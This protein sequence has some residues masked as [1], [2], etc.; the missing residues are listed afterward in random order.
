MA[1][2]GRRLVSGRDFAENGQVNARDVVRLDEEAARE[3]ADRLESAE[4]SVRSVEERPWRRTPHPPFMTSTLQQEAG[5]K[6]RFS[7]ARTMRVAQDLYEAGHIT[8][9]RTDST[10]LSD[11]ALQAARA[12]ARSLYGEEYVPARPR[13]YEKKVKNAQEAHEAIRPTGERFQPPGESGLHGDQRR[14]YELVWM[15]TVASQMADAV[16]QSV[17]VRLAGRSSAGAGHG[18]LPATPIDA[19][20]GTSGRVITFPGFLRAYVEGSD[21]PDAELEDREVRLPP[22]AV[23]DPLAALSLTPEGHSTQPPARYTEASLVKAL[24]D[25][26][27][28]RPSTYATILDTIEQRGYIWKKGSALVPSWTAFAV[29][30]L[31]ERYFG[32]LV[33]YGFTASMEEDLDDIARGDQEGVPWLSRFYFGNGQPGLKRLVSEHLG[34][35]DAR[36]INSIP[37]GGPDSGLVVR[38]GRYGPYLQRGDDE[39]AERAALPEDLAPDELTPERAAELLAAG[40]TERQLGVHPELGRTVAVRAGRFGPY[41][42][43][44]SAEEADGGRPLTASLLRSMDPA[45][46]TLEDALQVLSLPRVVGVDPGTGE[47]IVA[48]NGRYGP[49]LRRGSESRSLESEEQLFTVSLE[50]ALAFFA[51][52]PA[53]RGRGAAAAPLREL[54]PDP[55]SGATIVLRDGRFGPYVTDGTT[56]ASLRKGDTVDGINPERAAE[57]LADRR[58]APP[59]PGRSRAAAKKAGG[60]AKKSV[61][62][63]AKKAAPVKKASATKKTSASRASTKKKSTG[64]TP[65]AR[66]SASPTRKEA[67]D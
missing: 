58:A 13:R 16:G 38:V 11:E 17:V 43:V 4:F 1:L 54:G 41:V 20:F 49:Y 14:L 53:R 18:D 21:D 22:L 66:K 45:T 48:S 3:L 33:D 25:M 15:R 31:L 12:T 50:Q 42:Q 60:T 29:T 47:E 67:G 61:G 59:R 52:P 40:S 51:Q 19:E 2:D 56:N 7:A 27:V 37:I 36:Q 46:V 5:R 24:E 44:G 63:A 28:G 8:Y 65:A 6:L 26:G 35:I 30:G 57:L 23:G 39:G 55:E 10:T 64:K 62:A 34:E 32:E 9:M